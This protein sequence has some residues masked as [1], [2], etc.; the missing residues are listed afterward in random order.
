MKQYLQSALLALGLFTSLNLSATPIDPI[1]EIVRFAVLPDSGFSAAVGGPGI[2]TTSVNLDSYDGSTGT[3]SLGDGATI[4]FRDG[5]NHVPVV[6]DGDDFLWFDT[7]ELFIGT[8]TSVI[9]AAFTGM[10]V[11][12]ISF[13]LDTMWNSASGWLA[14]DFEG[15]YIQSDT[16]SIGSGLSSYGIFVA[17]SAGSCSG[18]SK[19]YVDPPVAA[20]SPRWGITNIQLHTAQSCGGVNV[21]E[22]GTLPLMLGALAVMGLLW[23]RQVRGRA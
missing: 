22:P 9:S 12:G 6:R 16:F 14:A 13:D 17:S 23:R 5:N 19:A 2:S 1:T 15:Q 20:E 7:S 11:V 3:V 8:G 21:P 18:M 4:A 10:T